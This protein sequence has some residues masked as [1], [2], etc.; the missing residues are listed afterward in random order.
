MAMHQPESTRTHQIPTK[1]QIPKLLERPTH[2]SEKT[3]CRSFCCF[4]YPSLKT[5]IF[6]NLKKNNGRPSFF[7]FFCSLLFP[8]S[9]QFLTASLSNPPDHRTE[10][11]NNDW[12]PLRGGS[13][14]LGLRAE[15]DQV[16]QGVVTVSRF[17]RW[18][19]SYLDVPG[20]KDQWLGSVGYFTPI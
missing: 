11:C 8:P 7:P 9:F 1:K 10:V 5:Q 4:V 19:G 18:L 14:T 15:V 2:P 6:R 3:N 13:T 12:T 17:S 20:R 16:T